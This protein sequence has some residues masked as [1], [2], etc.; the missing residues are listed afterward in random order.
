MSRLLMQFG[1]CTSAENSAPAKAAGW[2]FI[3]ENC[4]SILQGLVEDDAQWMGR[5]RAAQ[6]ALPVL[7]ANVL[8]PGSLKVTGPDFNEDALANYLHRVAER[9]K[10]IGIKTIVFGSGGA[11]NVPDGF[12]RDAAKAQLAD[13]CT[14]LGV[15]GAGSGIMFA[16]EPLRRQECNIINTVGEAMPYVLAI[17]QPSLQCLVDTYHLWSESE[18]LKNVRDAMPCIK[19]VHL[20]DLE[21]RVAPG[22]SGTSDYRPIFRILK[23]AKYDGL[24]SVEA[25]QFDIANDGER[26]LAFIKTEWE[27]A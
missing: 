16:V 11:R 17:N 13:F 4:Q 23:D 2:D 26:V 20:A 6:S 18:P 22:L 9:A 5:Q 8:L 12:D 27:N 7:S 25:T 24:I 1:I 15:I 19:H 14:A 10:I 3:E 21:G